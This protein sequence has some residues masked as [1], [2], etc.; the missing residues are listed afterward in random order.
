MV[1]LKLIFTSMI[2]QKHPEM[3]AQRLD[4]ITTL[5]QIII[6]TI[7]RFLPIEEAARTSILSREWRYKWTT[8]PKLVFLEDSVKEPNEERRLSS[9]KQ[10]SDLECDLLLHQGPIQE[11]TL[12]TMNAPDT[13][14]EIDQIILHL[15]RNHTVLKFRLDLDVF[16]LPL[17]LFSLH[18]LTDLSLYRCQIKHIPVFNRFGSLTSLSLEKVWIS[19]ESLLHLLSLCPSFTLDGRILGGYNTATI[20]EF[21]KCFP[22]IEHLTSSRYLTEVHYFYTHYRYFKEKEIYKHFC[23][24]HCFGI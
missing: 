20:M 8:I 13:C 18:Q 1:Y 3:K 14:F 12:T 11:F 6:E 22:E 5:P 2:Q 10:M 9:Q 23:F 7:L 16:R 4:I 21:F 24:N 15:S 19:M 17:S